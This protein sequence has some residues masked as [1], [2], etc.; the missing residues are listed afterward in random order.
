MAGEGKAAS[1]TDPFEEKKKLEIAGEGGAAN[2]EEEREPDGK[3]R[4]K[5]TP[6]QLHQQA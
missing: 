5:P 3:H 4:E 6:T 2:Q 1:R